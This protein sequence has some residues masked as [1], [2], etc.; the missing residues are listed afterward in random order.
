MDYKNYKSWLQGLQPPAQSPEEQLQQTVSDA[1]TKKFLG[2]AMDD[3]V[4]AKMIGLGLISNGYIDSSL[5]QLYFIDRLMR[6]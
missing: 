2:Q 4:L 5:G 1:R 3:N 6:K